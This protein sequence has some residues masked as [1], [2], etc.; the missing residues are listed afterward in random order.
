MAFENAIITKEN[1]E[2]YGLS[3]FTIS[4]IHRIKNL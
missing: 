1:D 2:K 3:K 4:I